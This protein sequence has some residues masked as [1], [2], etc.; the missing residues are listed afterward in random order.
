MSISTNEFKV[1]DAVFYCYREKHTQRAYPV[2][3]ILFNLVKDS[4]S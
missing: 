1:F 2:D 3:C 4:A